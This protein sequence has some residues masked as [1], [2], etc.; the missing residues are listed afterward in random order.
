MNDRMNKV[1][2]GGLFYLPFENLIIAINTTS[3]YY[4]LI[5]TRGLF[6]VGFCA[7]GFIY[8]ADVYMYQLKLFP[9]LP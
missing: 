2:E 4:K 3:Y 5:C 8:E 6:Y 1:G 7:K 9:Q